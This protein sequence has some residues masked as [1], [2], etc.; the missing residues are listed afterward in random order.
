MKCYIVNDEIEQEECALVI[1]ESEKAKNGKLLPKKFKRIT[2][3]NI[4][5]REC[6]NHIKPKITK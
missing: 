5:C 6:P 4:I 3:W 1:M 2:G